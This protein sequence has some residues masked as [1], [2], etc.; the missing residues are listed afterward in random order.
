MEQGTYYT[1]GITFRNE[2]KPFRYRYVLLKDASIHVPG[3]DFGK[4]KAVGADDNRL[5]IVADGEDFTIKADYAWDGCTHA[6]DYD[7]NM[8]ASLFHDAMYQAKK[9]GF[10]TASW[11]V[12]DNI[13]RNIMKQDGATL[14]Q[15]N[16]Y[17]YAVRSFGAIYKLEKFDS[18]IPG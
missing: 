4:W 9:C 14:V 5:Y 8:R 7:W 6:V 1:H 2:S 11:W 10:D 16:T 12:I 17:Y 13:F 18:L 15:R 3:V